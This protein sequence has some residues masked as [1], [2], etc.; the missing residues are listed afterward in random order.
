MRIQD[1]LP[2]QRAQL[3][4]QNLRQLLDSCEEI[5]VAKLLGCFA[6]ELQNDAEDLLWR[7]ILIFVYDTGVLTHTTKVVRSF[8]QVTDALGYESWE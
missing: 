4:H 1:S 8:K 5:T 6:D 3:R 7:M 2:E